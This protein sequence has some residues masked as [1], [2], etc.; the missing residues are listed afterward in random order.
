MERTEATLRKALFAA[1]NILKRYGDGIDPSDVYRKDEIDLVTKADLECEKAI[2]DVIQG[3]FPAHAILSEEGG[4]VSGSS[5]DGGPLWVIDPLDGTT[6]FSHGFPFYCISIAYMEGNL[7][8]LGGVYDPIRDDVFFAAKGKGAALNGRDI[9]VSGTDNLN[10]SLL[11]TGFPYDIR[12]S[13]ENNLD[14]FAEF[15]RSVQAVRRAGSA[16]LDLCYLACGRIDGFWEIKLH[17][18]DTAAA[19]L[20]IE[21]AGGRVTDFSGGPFDVFLK[22]C[23]ASNGTKLHD[24]LLE[25]IERVRALKP[26]TE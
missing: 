15:A 13:S 8:I 1:G 21:E 19:W 12:T 4:A 7:P 5:R 18:W 9:R 6:N 23:A 14:Y 16:A 20:I 17:P 3:A 10:E 26:P 24:E 25:V 22:E 11:A 2:C